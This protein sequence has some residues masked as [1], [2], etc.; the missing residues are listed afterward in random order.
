MDAKKYKHGLQHQVVIAPTDGVRVQSDVAHSDGGIGVVQNLADLLDRSPHAVH[1]KAACFAH[2]VCAQVDA[3]GDLFADRGE[4]A[5]DR[6]SCDRLG[7]RLPVAS[8]PVALTLE[9]P[10]IVRVLTEPAAN[11]RLG[12]GVDREDARLAGLAL[13]QAQFRAFGV[14]RAHLFHRDGQ[15]IGNTQR[16]VNAELPDVGVDLP[17]VHESVLDL[18]ALTGGFDGFDFVHGACPVPA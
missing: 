13:D 17:F 4:H 7:A 9:Q 3:G 18:L 8:I 11:Y 12:T 6:A 14:Q 10:D 5:A 16:G 15:Q 1:G 2:G